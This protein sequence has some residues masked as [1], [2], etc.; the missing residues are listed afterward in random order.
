MSYWIE[1]A[2]GY[3]G[4]FATN[5]GIAEMRDGAPDSLLRFLDAGEADEELVEELISDTRDDDR[6][7]YVAEMLE[8]VKP[9]VT[10]TDGCGHEEDGT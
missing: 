3:V 7:S 8:G 2:D 10:I 6:L 1:D 4:D 5:V 9:P